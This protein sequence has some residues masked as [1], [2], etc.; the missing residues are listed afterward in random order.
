MIRTVGG[1]SDGLCCLF[2]CMFVCIVCV[3][4]IYLLARF[5]ILVCRKN[6]LVLTKQTRGMMLD[7]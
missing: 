1:M 7:G 2:A 5:I 3:L 4:F 6:A